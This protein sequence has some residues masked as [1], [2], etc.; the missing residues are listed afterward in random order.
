MIGIK[1][2]HAKTPPENT[3]IDILR[4]IINPTDTKAGDNEIP[5]AKID[6]RPKKALEKFREIILFQIAKT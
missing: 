5:N 2:N 4:P 6:L 3:I 1:I